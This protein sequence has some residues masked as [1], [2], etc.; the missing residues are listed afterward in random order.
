[1]RKIVSTIAVGSLLISSSATTLNVA[2][3]EESKA[4]LNKKLTEN[5]QEQEE[6]G[7]QIKQLDS[8]IKEIESK[9]EVTEEKISKLNSETEQTKKEIESLQKSIK[10]NEDALGQRLKVIDNNYS[11]GYIKVVLSSNS[12]SDF[13]NNLYM[14]KEVIEQDRVLL[15]ELEED[16]ASVEEK[17]KELEIKSNEQ[18]ELKLSLEADNNKVES[19][20]AEVE[21]L[22][23]D[24]IK[25]EDDLESD[26]AKIIAKEEAEAKAKAE[27]EAQQNNSSNNQG[28]SSNSSNQVV[29]S[30]S[31]PVPGYSRISS[32]YGN[33]IHPVLGTTKFHT[34]IDIPAPKGAPVTAYDD[35]TVIYSGV[36]GS[37]GNTVMIR[38]DDGKVTLYAHNSALNVSVGQRV[39]KGQV[40]SKVGSTGRS[41]G[42]HL[43]F[44]VRV[45]GKHV[46]PMNYL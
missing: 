40:V 28:S 36:Q 43:H 22:K 15:K 12:L 35:G 4:T 13:F 16:K 33:R 32:P 17:K 39:Q 20:K 46:N 2:Y 44:E 14:V 7:A 29:T 45:N 10:E 23:N 27:A 9:I 8:Q 21:K 1:M 24:L 38:H 19:D 37:Y 42:P 11:M 5:R 25:E 6:L 31:W 26:I 3:A 30:G 41:T 34:G 18:K